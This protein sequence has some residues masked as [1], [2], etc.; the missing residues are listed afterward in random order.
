MIIYIFW[1]ESALSHRGKKIFWNGN[2]SKYSKNENTC[3]VGLGWLD[4]TYKKKKMKRNSFDEIEVRIV[5]YFLWFR[6]GTEQTKQKNVFQNI[7]L[8]PL[9]HS[10][11]KIFFFRGIY[12][13]ILYVFV[14]RRSFSFVLYERTHGGNYSSTIIC[15]DNVSSFLSYVFQ[16]IVLFYNL[17]LVLTST[18]TLDPCTQSHARTNTWFTADKILKSLVNGASKKYTIRSNKPAVTL[19]NKYISMLFFLLYIFWFCYRLNS[20]I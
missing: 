6:I 10:I 4:L 17:F 11:V 15:N 19:L 14:V 2:R 7:L 20:R 12:E 9:I 13:W 18:S 3:F 16:E 5:Y 8:M 1:N